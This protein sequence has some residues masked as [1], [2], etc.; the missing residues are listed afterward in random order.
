MMYTAHEIR[1]YCRKD[2]KM[3]V[4]RKLK[5]MPYAQAGWSLENSG[6]RW[7]MYSYSSCI[8]SAYVA[9]GKVVSIDTW[10][11]DAAINYSRTTSR[12]VTAAMQE[13]GLSSSETVALK[14]FFTRGGSVAC[15]GN[16]SWFN[17]ETGELIWEGVRG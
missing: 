9:G 13:L 16:G 7:I 11:A 6:E 8:F 14:R 1:G 17:G 2:V 15:I 3:F 12:Q 5:Y 10:R 4:N